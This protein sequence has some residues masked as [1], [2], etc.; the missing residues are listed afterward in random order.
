MPEVEENNSENTEVVDSFSSV[1]QNSLDNELLREISNDLK[2]INENEI[3]IIQRLDNLSGS[4]GSVSSND[5]TAIKNGVNSILEETV[6][7]NEIKYDDII[8][9]DFSEYTLTESLLLIMLIVLFLSLVYQ[10]FKGK[11]YF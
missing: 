6:S 10:F 9:R 7:A 5:I 4:S 2:V 11:N 1:S 3:L 8:T